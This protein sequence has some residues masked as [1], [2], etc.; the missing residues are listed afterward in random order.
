MSEGFRPKRPED[1]NASK[2]FLKA[3]GVHEPTSTADELRLLREEIRQLREALNPPK[4]ALIV[5]ADV[6]R[7]LRTL[8]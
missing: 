3:F 8:K 4:S 1:F 6:E 5:G 7:I 2:D